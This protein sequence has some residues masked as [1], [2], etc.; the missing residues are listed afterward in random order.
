MI[1]LFEFGITCIIVTNYKI[2]TTTKNECTK[3]EE[4]MIHSLGERSSSIND[5]LSLGLNNS[6]QRFTSKQF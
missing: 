5:C 2:K 1:Q 4:M 3:E 6:N